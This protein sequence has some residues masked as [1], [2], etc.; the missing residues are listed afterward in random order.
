MSLASQLLASQRRPE[1]EAQRIVAA[2][3][4]AGT[5]QVRDVIDQ[6]SLE[7]ADEKSG[8]RRA[9]PTGH[10]A[11][12][13][14][15][16]PG[17][18]YGDADDRPRANP[19]L[20]PRF[21]PGWEPESEP[22]PTQSAWE[23]EPEPEP[24]P[25]ST[26]IW[27]PAPDPLPVP[28][29]DPRRP[30]RQFRRP[31][32][33]VVLGGL[34]GLAV[35]SLVV[36]GTVTGTRGRPTPA[37]AVQV[38]APSTEVEAPPPAADDSVL[39]PA[40]VSASCGNDSDAVAPFSGDVT[41]AWLCERRFGLDGNILNVSFAEPVVITQICVVPGWNYVAPDGRDE[42][43]RHRIAASVSWR[44]GGQ[45][46][47]QKLT[48]T[49]T[50]VCQNFPGVITQEMSMTITAS[51]RPA[52]EPGQKRGMFGDED[53]YDPEEIDRHT[54]VG[55]VAVTGHLVDQGGAA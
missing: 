46:F 45:L 44:M 27:D 25:E 48:P 26:S 37:P 4:E 43:A 24:T 20:D 14:E 36:V 42:W 30:R 29:R 52:A 23:A 5:D 32:L 11:G 18:V 39:V 40:T 16:D 1:A 50:G 12:F 34:A 35:V 3:A 54:A 53:S 8:P 7:I 13:E 19:R 15:Q 55:K 38:P 51:A 9:I 28:P 6:V 47:P 17:P 31:S 41:R 10:A 22:E 2:V 49:R 33:G 21:L